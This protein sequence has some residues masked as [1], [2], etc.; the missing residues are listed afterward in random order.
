VWVFGRYL[1][2]TGEEG[3]YEVTGNAV[4]LRPAP[5]SDV[6]NFPL[7]QR[8][9][10]G[11]KVRGIELAEQGKPLEETWVRVWSPPGVRAYVKSASVEPLPANEDGKS[12]WTAALGLLPAVPPERASAARPTEPDPRDAT[13]PRRAPR[14]RKR[15]SRWSASAFARHRTTT[16]SKPSCRPWSRA[17][18]PWR[19]RRAASCARSRRCA[20]PPR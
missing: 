17:A 18:A 19:S 13:T 2:A 10:A 3:L 8:L 7:P 20:R 11:D 14:S 15:A 9:Q 6:T 12:A 4:N 1:K 5:S 16:R